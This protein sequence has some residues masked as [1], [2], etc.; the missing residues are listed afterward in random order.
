MGYRV[1][2]LVR[3]GVFVLFIGSICIYNFTG[4]KGVAYMQCFLL[5]G[6]GSYSITRHGTHHSGSDPSPKMPEDV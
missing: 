3:A 5:G 4:N 2:F 6:S 1:S